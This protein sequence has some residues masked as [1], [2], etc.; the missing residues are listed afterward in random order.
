MHAF[1]TS[2][3]PD[4][5]ISP[6][7]LEIH[8]ETSIGIAEIRN[9]QSF[10]SRKPMQSER[11]VVIIHEAQLL[12]RDAQQAFLKTLEEPPSNS[13]IYLLT[14][15]PDQLLPTILSRVDNQTDRSLPQIDSATLPASKI[16]F[17]KLLSAKVGERLTILDAADF[18]RPAALQF[19]AD[20][21]QILHQE[22]TTGAPPLELRGGRG[23]YDLISTTRTYLQANVNLK[24][25]LDHF[26]IKL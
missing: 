10:L 9:I 2:V 1:L 18:D 14:Q 22:I 26:A 16:I 11:N 6:D 3:R 25:A 21:E 4:I 5:K 7:L 19:L 15:F 8:P 20:V 23:S 13:Q 17:E 24:L 12:T